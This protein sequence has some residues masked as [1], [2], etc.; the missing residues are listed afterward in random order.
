MSINHYCALLQRKRLLLALIFCVSGIGGASARAN[1]RDSVY[2]HIDSIRLEG[3]HKTNSRLILREL[4]F[5][6]LHFVMRVAMPN[7]K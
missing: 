2:V 7:V 5:A 1:I 4:E 3:N 6:M